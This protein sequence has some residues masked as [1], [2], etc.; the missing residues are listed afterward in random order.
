MF[1]RKL[2]GENINH[3]EFQLVSKVDENPSKGSIVINKLF[4]HFPSCSRKNDK[5]F[6]IPALYEY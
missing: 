4:V 3:S 5:L 2:T 1:L 6:S